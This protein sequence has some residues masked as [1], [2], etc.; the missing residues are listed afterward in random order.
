MS[1]SMLRDK[2]A[3]LQDL[4]TLENIRKYEIENNVYH[5]LPDAVI[6]SRDIL[7]DPYKESKI[8]IRRLKELGR[9]SS[10]EVDDYSQYIPSTSSTVS[11]S[12][13]FKVAMDGDLY[14][15]E[16]KLSKAERYIREVLWVLE[17]IIGESMK[18]F[19]ILED[20]SSNHS[21]NYKIKVLEE[22]K[23]NSTLKRVVSL[24]L[25]SKILFYI[26]KIPE[27]VKAETELELD[28]ALDLIESNIA[29]RKVTGNAA[30]SL[31][32]SILS[33]LSEEDADVLS[34]VILKDL[35][36]GIAESTVNKVWKGL[37]S[38][39][40]VMLCSQF[41]EK[42]VSKIK[43]PAY[44]QLKMDGMRINAVVNNN[45][46]TLYSRNGKVVEL[47]SNTLEKEFLILSASLGKSQVVFD[48]ELV[49]YES[50]NIANRQTGNGILNKAV[51][52]TISESES[53]TVHATI[54][55]VIEYNA[56]I[57]GTKDDTKYKD[58]Y[59]K[60]KNLPY[61]EVSRI[62]PVDTHIVNSLEEA[63][64]IYGKYIQEGQEG[65]I[66]KS[67]DGIWEN[68]RTK[69]QVKMK[70][71]STCDLMV[72]DWIEGTGKYKNMLGALLCQSSD[73]TLSVN[74]GS[75]FSEEQR[76]SITKES[77]VGK[78]IEVKY[79]GKIVSKTGKNSLFLPIFVKVRLD[80]ETADTF[81]DIK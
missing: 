27:F 68:K 52:G 48:G 57:A 9:L 40:P 33:K 47:L 8:Q 79:N 31:V 32:S 30:L 20:I 71:E 76:T 56:F 61:N 26:K 41:D 25:D 53:E 12:L 16:E 28:E 72:I 17:H 35:K 73:G 1:I 21:K 50:G 11:F 80:K 15:T 7:T 45:S 6:R 18:V 49:V 4:K 22:N 66:L 64:D 78:V 74:V 43:Y 2:R 34:R 54:W 23:D 67:T 77:V 3:I 46:V 36:C 44:A 29:S 69:S 70:N 59:N 42:V 24:A 62:K 5:V 75:G 58:R 81:D 19:Y 60:I 55:D 14:L 13:T 65:I 63:Q 37:I 51:R 38:E 10:E 39:H